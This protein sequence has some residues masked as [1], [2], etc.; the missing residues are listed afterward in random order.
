MSSIAFCRCRWWCVPSRG[1]EAALLRCRW[2]GAHQSPSSSHRWQWPREAQRE[3]SPVQCRTS[4]D[5]QPQTVGKKERIRAVFS[6]HKKTGGNNYAT[7]II[8][9]QIQYRHSVLATKRMAPTNAQAALTHEQTD[10]FCL[11]AIR[12]RNPLFSLE[13]CRVAAL[14]PAAEPY[15]RILHTNRCHPSSNFRR[16]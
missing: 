10:R 11:R 13:A 4:H 1:R 5:G 7:F 2:L 16:A 3:C 15:R 6:W 12:V 9:A 8:H 14:R